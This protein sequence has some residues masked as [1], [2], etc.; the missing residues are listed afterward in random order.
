MSEGGETQKSDQATPKRDPNEG[1]PP[2]VQRFSIRDSG[3]SKRFVEEELKKSRET[4]D[5]PVD[6]KSLGEAIDTSSQ[7]R[8]DALAKE[9]KPGL[10]P[11]VTD[12]DL[13]KILD[14]DV[15]IP[16]ELR[17][18]IGQIKPPNTVGEVVK[19]YVNHV[20]KQESARIKGSKSA[21][22]ESKEQDK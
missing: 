21:R 9:G 10:E 4:G 11:P 2:G 17:E 20:A 8:R 22:Q 12:E 13:R 6:L 7:W 1:A 5:K 15:E 14:Q 16:K 3:E 19:R 18:A